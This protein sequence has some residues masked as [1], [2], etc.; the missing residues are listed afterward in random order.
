MST[1]ASPVRLQACLNG[2]RA[3]GAHPM[4]PLNPKELASDAAACIAAGADSVHVHPRGGNGEQ[5]LDAEAVD[6]AVL[7][8]RDA[9]GQL[10][11]VSTSHTI[12]ADPAR[13]SELIAAWEEP[14]FASVNLS[15][16]DAPEIIALLLDKD[17]AI[18]AGIWSVD[19]VHALVKSG[20]ANRVTRVL[21]EPQ[22]IDPATALST[23]AAIHGA[24]DEHGIAAPR[25]Q[26]G[27]GAAAWVTLSDALDRG[28]AT[29]IGFEDTLA[30]DGGDEAS[31]NADLVRAVASRAGLTVTH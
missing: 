1:A 7:A 13:R 3:F 4:L 9:T 12:D 6:A 2:D 27:V 28:L 17:I 23:V 26:H 14:D 11:G 15:E 22:E 20:F 16:S 5:T 18:E 10:V 30:L 29:R 8:I 19:D 25:L 24:L 31:S 21:I